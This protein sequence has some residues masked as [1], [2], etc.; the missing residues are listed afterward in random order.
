M[1]AKA[2]KHG[3]CMNP[4]CARKSA[5]IKDGYCSPC[6]ARLRYWAIKIATYGPRVLVVRQNQIECWSWTYGNLTH[7]TKRRPVLRAIA[8]GKR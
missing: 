8:G 5:T 3:P 7:E 4:R 2:K 1:R 6:D